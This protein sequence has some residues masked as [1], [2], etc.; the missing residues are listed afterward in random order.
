MADSAVKKLLINN[1]KIQAVGS[2]TESSDVVVYLAEQRLIRQVRDIFKK[3]A[4]LKEAQANFEALIS[5]GTLV[6]PE[7]APELFN[8]KKINPNTE[9]SE[10]IIE[11]LERVWETKE[12]PYISQGV[13]TRPDF[14]C[15]DEKGAIAL[16]NWMAK[17]KEIPP[18]LRLLSKSDAVSLI[19]E[20]LEPDIAKKVISAYQTKVYKKMHR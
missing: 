12:K 3:S 10:T 6:L 2:K 11:F 4:S 1:S 18:H 7:V 14:R 20:N 5:K 19:L 9:K 15:L 16:K 8:H 13:L 17:K